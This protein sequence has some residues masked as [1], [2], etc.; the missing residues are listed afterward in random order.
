MPAMRAL[1]RPFLLPLLRRDPAEV[2]TCAARFCIRSDPGR[3]FVS[4]L[5]QAFIGGYNVMLAAP[6]LGDVVREG[7]AV[8]VHFRPFFFEGAAMGYL[9]RAYHRGGL[10]MATA[11][12]DLLEM[13]ARFLYL[14]Y[15]GLGF[16][17]GFRH[18]RRPAALLALAG[19]LAPLY[20]PLCFDGY[21][22]KTGFFDSADEGRALKRL[23]LCPAAHRGAAY[24]G[25]GR[26][27][28]FVYMDDPDGFDALRSR[29]DPRHAD[30]LEIGRSLGVVFTGVDRPADVAKHLESARDTA[31]LGARLTGATWG[32]AARRMNDPEYFDRCLAGAGAAR[33]LFLALLAECD[34]A[35]EHA[36]D[37]ETWQR[38]TRASLLAV[39][40]AG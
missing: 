40:R 36:S 27:M 22:F 23:A 2:E 30:D 14:Y 33:P 9:P 8:P 25:F 28:H 13:D 24:Q 31:E 39:Y 5:G 29:V 32:L 37:Y 19:H 26:A 4:S 1:L 20:Y 35:L 7:H 17:F 38:D 16:W 12:R 6:T 21:G 3:R 34:R 18:P 10:G 15:I 11:E